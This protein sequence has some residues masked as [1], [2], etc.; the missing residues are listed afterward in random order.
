M[1]EA[2]ELPLSL[3]W[4]RSC[5]AFS[6][7][8]SGRVASKRGAG[9]ACVRAHPAIPRDRRWRASLRVERLSGLDL[10][11][12]LAPASPRAPPGR[13][14]LCA[15]LNARGAGAPMA[16]S[17]GATLAL[18]AGDVVTIVGDG[19][20]RHGLVVLHGHAEKELGCELTVRARELPCVRRRVC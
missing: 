5:A 3:S 14:E 13:A 17:G 10:A 16:C 20:T 15:A 19:H 12:G 9:W 7:D 1:P 11:V 18:A 6:V 8:S 4:E 2:D